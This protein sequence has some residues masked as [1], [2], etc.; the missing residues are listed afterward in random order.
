MRGSL[1]VTRPF[2][3]HF[4]ATRQQLTNACN[5]LFELVGNDE[6]KIHIGQTY[7]LKD[8]AQAHRDLE[9][10]KTRGSTILLP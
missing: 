8:A 3:D 9:A 10:R 7:S 6:I 1:Y 2:L 4:V 5:E